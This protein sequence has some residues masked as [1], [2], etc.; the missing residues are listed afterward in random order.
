MFLEI[1][2]TNCIKSVDMGKNSILRRKTV[3]DIFLVYKV[4]DILSILGGLMRGRLAGFRS[5][6]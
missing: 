5:S 3:Q 1:I 6:V 4:L 2:V